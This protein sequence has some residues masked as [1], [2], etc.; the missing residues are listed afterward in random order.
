MDQDTSFNKNT[1]PEMK[2]AIEQND[3][4][5]IGIVTPWQNTKLK[6]SK[7]IHLKQKSIYGSLNYKKKGGGFSYK[8]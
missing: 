6:V 7:P 4:S 5:R 2:K 1:L 3:T 8:K